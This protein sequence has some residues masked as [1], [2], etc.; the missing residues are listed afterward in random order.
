MKDI[1][2]ISIPPHI[3]EFL[4]KVAG[5][6]HTTRVFDGT[7]GVGSMLLPALS[8]ELEQSRTIDADGGEKKKIEN[9]ILRNHIWGIESDETLYRQTKEKLRPVCGDSCNLLHGN[10]FEQVEFIRQ[11]DPDVI[12]MNPPFNTPV[13]SIPDQYK[14]GWRASDK[15]DPTKGMVFLLPL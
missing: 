6:N 5:V 9:E 13:S 12:L 1:N 10:L 14:T 3:A 8:A 15:E 2:Q 4:C 11:A 7:C